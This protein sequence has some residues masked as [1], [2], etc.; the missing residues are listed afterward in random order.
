[1]HGAIKDLVDAIFVFAPRYAGIAWQRRSLLT[2]AF[3]TLKGWLVGHSAINLVGVAILALSLKKVPETLD[4]KLRQ[5]ALH[6]ALVVLALVVGVFAQ[7]RLFLYHFGTVWPLTALL[8]GWGFWLLWEHM[9]QRAASAVVY[10]AFMI[11]L[12]FWVTVPPGLHDSFL[13]RS[14]MR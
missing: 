12:A 10:A 13:A 5:G 4:T 8:G 6:V 14:I 3:L 11:T 2:L 9:R 7:A 1:A